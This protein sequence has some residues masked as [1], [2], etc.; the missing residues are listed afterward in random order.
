[1]LGAVLTF[2]HLPWATE[3]SPPK[4]QSN[5]VF[6]GALC[7]VVPMVQLLACLGRFPTLGPIHLK[8]SL[9]GFVLSSEH[10]D[11]LEGK[12]AAPETRA[13]P[14]N[15]STPASIKPRWQLRAVTDCKSEGWSRRTAGWSSEMARRGTM[16]GGEAGSHQGHCLALDQS[17]ELAVFSRCLSVLLAVPSHQLP[18]TAEVGK[19]L[20]DLKELL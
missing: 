2:Q 6:H 15:H 8:A 7:F 11:F 3:V 14:S 20:L 19:R 1:M 18:L 4:Q 10:L 13:S 9:C 5:S 12:V 16:V 17:Q